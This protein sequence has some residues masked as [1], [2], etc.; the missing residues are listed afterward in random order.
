VIVVTASRRD[1]LGQAETA[2]QGTVTHAEVALRPIYR[3][4]QLLESVPGLVVTIHSGEGKAQ[5]YLIR[6]YNLDHGTDF[7]S[8]VDDMPVNRPTNAH[9][10]GYS[11][12][13]F[14]MPQLVAGID[15]TKGPYAAAIGDFGSVASAHTRLVNE[16]PAQVA[17]TVGTDGYQ[18][19]FAGGTFHLGADKRLLAAVELGHYD[20]P[21]QPG[22]NFRK[23]NALLRYSQGSARDGFT[24]TAM[25]Y[26]S[27]GRLTTDQPE[28]A[29]EEGLIGRYGTLD[30]T[31]SSKSQRYSLSAH[32]DRPVGPGQLAVSLY[33]IRSTMTLWNNFTHYLDD[34]V[35]GDQEE[36]DESRTTLGA[37]AAYTIATRI[38]GL[39]SQTVA[40]FQLRYDAAFVDRKHT[41]QRNTILAT[42]YQQ[43]DSGTFAYAAVGGNCTADKVR[44]L[45][46]SPYVEE[47]LHLARWLRVVGGLRADYTY[48]RDHSL[49]TGTGGSGGQ[50]LAQPKGSLVLGPWAKTELYVSWGRGF[51]SNDVRGVFGTVPTQ[52]LSV[53]GGARTPLLSS[54]TGMEVGLRSNLLPKLSLQLAAFQQDFGSELVYNPD[55]GQDEAGAPSRRQGVEISAQYRPF[56]WLELNTDLAFSRP[57]Y[58][59]ADLAAYGLAEPY[60]ADAPNFIYAAGVLVNGLGRWS[61]AL[62]W[63]RLGTHSLNDG[64]KYPQ[65]GGYSEWNL[66]VGYALPRGW[67]LGVSIF[68]LFNS[69]DAA[70]DYYYTAR[71]QGEPA[72]G[73]A[74]FQTHPLEPRSAR[75]T[76]GKTF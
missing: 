72:D 53:S 7:A 17:A 50:W 10:Q 1:L 19:V 41:W 13:N 36:Q 21:W 4:G 40:G 18:N 32:L 51:H 27:A 46:L 67:R 12:L 14:L 11:D 24:L 57:R 54:T 30:P 23:V 2:S 33:A 15:Y 74:G 65:D 37:A 63:R 39:D 58:H 59:T 56:R 35:Y 20:G 5:Q 64:Y 6:G 38:A 9:G 61:G 29:I 68:N 70:A 43:S 69:H 16:L 3:P 48:A 52:G 71:L 66:D 75:F 60:I 76:I 28:R 55:T 47:T 73:V 34:P 49:V 8:F 45:T 26:A 31:D 25:A 62:Q 42:C 44:L 22:Q